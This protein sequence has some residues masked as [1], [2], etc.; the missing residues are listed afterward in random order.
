MISFED[1]LQIVLE[2]TSFSGVEEIDFTDGLGRYLAT[3]VVSDIDIP[4]FTRSAMDG[5]A[6]RRNELGQALEVIEVVQAGYSPTKKI[7]PGQCAQIMTGAMLPAG[8]DCVIKVEET[9][10]T[11]EGQVRFVG[12][13][14]KHNIRYKGEDAVVG[15]K[16]LEKGILLKPQHLAICATV[17][18]VKIRVAKKPRV[19]IMVTGDEIVNPEVKPGPS[20][21][22]NSNAFQ[23]I[24]QVK[25]AGVIP[26]YYGIVPDSKEATK[27]ALENALDD[28]DVLLFTGGVSMGEFDFIPEVMQQCGVEILFTKMAVKPGKP[29]TFGKKGNKLVFG[30]PGNPVSSFIQLEIVVKPALRKMMGAKFLVD[31]IMLPIVEDKIQKQNTRMSWFPVYIND[32]GMAEPLNYHGSAHLNAFDKANAISYFPEGISQFHKGDLIHVRPI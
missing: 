26:H 6:C 19:A 11:P 2:S 5:Y 14:P 1:A 23:M 9:E 32:K 20:Q 27:A 7:G 4:P 18:A 31:E 25:Q 3:D 10:K 22:R 17:G 12:K 30:L 21:I 16:V 24:G 15:G 28:N 13:E 29:T 8:A